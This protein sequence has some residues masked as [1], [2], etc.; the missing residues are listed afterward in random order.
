MKTI[1]LTQLQY[2]DALK[3]F[4]EAIANGEKLEYFDD[5]TIGNKDTQCT[6]GLCCSD[7]KMWP[8]DARLFDRDP[9][10][11]K[12]RK[13]NHK[14]P[15]DKRNKDHD[16]GCFY[17]CRVFQGPKPTRVEALKLYDEELKKHGS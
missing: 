4:R 17:H 5:T 3:R 8:K 2:V 10:S 13:A 11:I 12:Y 6:W 7:K 16:F 1:H 14:C 9:I 15:M